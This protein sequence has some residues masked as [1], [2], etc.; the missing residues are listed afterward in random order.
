MSTR[1]DAI[2][3]LMQRGVATIEDL[4]EEVMHAVLAADALSKRDRNALFA[5]ARAQNWVDAYLSPESQ[6]S[7]RQLYAD[8]DQAIDDL[9]LEEAIAK[10]FGAG[11]FNPFERGVAQRIVDFLKDLAHV[12]RLRRDPDRIMRG[13]DQDGVGEFGPVGRQAGPV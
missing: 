3:I 5:A 11:D 13:V 4:D 6:Q 8:G 10:R 1:G 2:K 7:Y 12:L 9:L